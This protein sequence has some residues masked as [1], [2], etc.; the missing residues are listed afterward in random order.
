MRYYYHNNSLN[1]PHQCQIQALILLLALVSSF[2]HSNRANYCQGSSSLFSSF[3]SS[4]ICSSSSSNKGSK[5]SSRYLF[6]NSK[7]RSSMWYKASSKVS[8]SSSNNL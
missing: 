1:S 8:N 6:S 7:Y 5:V 3:C 2:I 4:T